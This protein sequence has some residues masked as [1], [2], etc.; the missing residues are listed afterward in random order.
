MTVRSP[1]LGLQNHP[2]VSS[3]A[4]PLSTPRQEFQGTCTVTSSTPE[5]SRVS[6]TLVPHQEGRPVV[7]ASRP[8]GAEG[9]Q[10]ERREPPS[11]PSS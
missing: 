11:S 6:S 4:A 1:W 7:G 9:L 2:A 3:M 5:V 8:Q 10:A